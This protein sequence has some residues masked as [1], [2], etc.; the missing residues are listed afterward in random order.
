MSRVDPPVIDCLET[1]PSAYVYP[2]QLADLLGLKAHTVRAWCRSGRIAGAKHRSP[3]EHGDWLIP[4]A[5]ALLLQQRL[6]F[7][8][9]YVA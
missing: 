2:R 5:A 3:D 8:T 1:W 9:K 7:N 6:G 4:K